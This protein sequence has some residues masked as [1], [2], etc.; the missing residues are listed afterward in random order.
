MW[1]GTFPKLTG[2]KDPVCLPWKPCRTP[3][4]YN[5]WPSIIEDT[6]ILKRIVFLGPGPEAWHSYDAEFMPSPVIYAIP[7]TPYNDVPF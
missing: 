6:E 1:Y 7:L 3:I 5:T 2:I 4:L